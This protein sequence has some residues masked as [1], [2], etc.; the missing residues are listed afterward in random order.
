MQIFIC[1]FKVM[2][3][4][5]QIAL[6]TGSNRCANSEAQFSEHSNR[7][8]E[9]YCWARKQHCRWLGDLVILLNDYLEFIF[10]EVC[11]KLIFFGEVVKELISQTGGSLF[12]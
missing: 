5:S 12:K 8:C 7:Y 3:R 6:V 2:G 1:D 4:A 11:E 10:V 9:N